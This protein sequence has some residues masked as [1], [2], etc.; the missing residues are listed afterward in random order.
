[1][2]FLQLYLSISRF[3]SCLEF[4]GKINN[5]KMKISVHFRWNDRFQKSLKMKTTNMR[6]SPKEVIYFLHKKNIDV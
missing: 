5:S 2:K 3:F 6:M 4:S 1:M